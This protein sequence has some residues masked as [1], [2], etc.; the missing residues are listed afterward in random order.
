MKTNKR[1]TKYMG[2]KVY[3]NGYTPGGKIRVFTDT[4]LCRFNSSLKGE[5]NVSAFIS[6]DNKNVMIRPSDWKHEYWRVVIK[7]TETGFEFIGIEKSK[8]AVQ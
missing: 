1:K 3:T 7:G 8:D 6:Y 5:P 2:S 4:H